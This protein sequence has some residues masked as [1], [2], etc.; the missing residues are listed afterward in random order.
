[1]EDYVFYP[2]VIPEMEEKPDLEL[3]YPI[4]TLELTKTHA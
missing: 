4:D 1:M 3:Q 2:S